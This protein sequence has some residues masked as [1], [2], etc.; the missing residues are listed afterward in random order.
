[1]KLGNTS[2]LTPVHEDLGQA[3]Q[4]KAPP[5]LRAHAGA[6]SSPDSEDCLLCSGSKLARSHR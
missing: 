5:H 3:E 4:V 6:P 1:M 2:G